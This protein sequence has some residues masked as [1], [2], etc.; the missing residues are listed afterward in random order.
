MRDLFDLLRAGAFTHTPSDDDCRYC[1]FDRA[2]GR[3]PA[4]RAEAK[5]DNAQNAMLAAY[6]RLQAH[7]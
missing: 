7:A 3:R 6:R 1:D 4:E 5:I 2:C